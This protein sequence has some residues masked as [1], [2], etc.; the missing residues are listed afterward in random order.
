MNSISSWEVGEFIEQVQLRPTIWFGKDM[1][2]V[3]KRDGEN[4]LAVKFVRD[5]GVKRSVAEMCNVYVKPLSG[6]EGEIAVDAAERYVEWLLLKLTSFGWRTKVEQML[7][8]TLKVRGVSEDEISELA[9]RIT[10]PENFSLPASPTVILA[11]PVGPTPASISI[12]ET[13]THEPEKP[14]V[15]SRH[16]QNLLRGEKR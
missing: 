13:T 4:E 6:G 1:L 8:E 10:A 3:R 2:W 9:L 14:R 7:R 15:L 5:E 16:L 12:A 11:F